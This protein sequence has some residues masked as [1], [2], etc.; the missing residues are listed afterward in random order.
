MRRWR[1]QAH[2]K[3]VPRMLVFVGV[4]IGIGIAIAI[5]DIPKSIPIATPIPIPIPGFGDI[6][7]IFGTE[8]G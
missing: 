2:E 4:G 6:S 8:T 5:G 7:S 3:D 1:T